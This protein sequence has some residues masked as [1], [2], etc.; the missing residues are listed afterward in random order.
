[1]SGRGGAFKRLLLGTAVSQLRTHLHEEMRLPAD[2]HGVLCET[3]G[4]D[5]RDIEHGLGKDGAEAHE[6]TPDESLP[7]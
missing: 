7:P 4:V 1:V 6:A 3:V 2:A 5:V